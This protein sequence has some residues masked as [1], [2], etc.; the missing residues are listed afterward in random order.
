M[1]FT[2]I[3]TLVI[4]KFKNLKFFIELNLVLVYKT[5]GLFTFTL[6]FW[7]QA[8]SL[9]KLITRCSFTLLREFTAGHLQYTLKWLQFCVL[10]K[11]SVFV[12][13]F[14]RFRFYLKVAIVSLK[15]F[16]KF[17]ITQIRYHSK[18]NYQKKLTWI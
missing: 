18:N 16:V 6:I 12:L 2:S 13:S 15:Y 8:Y 9:M 14:C 17:G 11:F 10:L 4:V 3:L 7:T 5:D 1:N